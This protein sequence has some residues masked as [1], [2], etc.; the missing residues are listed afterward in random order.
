MFLIT[1]FFGGREHIYSVQ[2]FKINFQCSIINFKV[3]NEIQ[4]YQLQHSAFDIDNFK[5]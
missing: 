4:L 5:N 1:I 2:N 3:N